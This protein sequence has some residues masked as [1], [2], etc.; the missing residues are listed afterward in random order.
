M[1]S[2]ILFIFLSIHVFSIAQY[3]ISGI[4]DSLLIGANAIKRLHEVQVNIIKPGKA[5]VKEKHVFTILNAEGAKYAKYSTGYSKFVSVD[6]L[7]AVLYDAAGNVVRKAKK[8]D[9]ADFSGTDES[10]LITDY[11]VKSFSFNYQIY[12]YTVEFLEEDTYDGLFSLPGCMPI[13]EPYVSLEKARLLVE[14]PIGYPLLH[15]E[16]EVTGRHEQDAR[17]DRYTWNFASAKAKTPLRFSPPIRSMYPAVFLAPGSFEIEGYPGKLDSWASFGLFMNDLYK[18][19]DI[20]P[21]QERVAINKITAS[22]TNTREKVFATYRYMQQNTRYI[23][24][25]LGLGGWQPLDASFVSTKKYGDCKALS[26]YMVALLK[27]IGI[28]GYNVIIRAGDD[29][30]DIDTDFPSNQFNHVIVCVPNQADT[31]WLECTSQTI[32]PG[33]LGAFTAGRHGILF[34][35]RGGVLVKTPDYYKDVNIQNRF[36]LGSIDASGTLIASVQKRAQGI[37]QDDEHGFVLN[38]TPIDQEQRLKSSI[39]LPHYDIGDLKYVIS[40]DEPLLTEQYTLEANSFA[41]LTDKRIF[42]QPFFYSEFFRKITDTGSR[43]YP[44]YFSNYEFVENDSIVLKLPKGFEPE[45][46]PRPHQFSS[47]FGEYTLNY[48]WKDDQIIVKRKLVCAKGVF[49]P[50]LFGLLARFIEDVTKFD[51]TR[52]VFIRKHE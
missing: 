12:P 33:Y 22:L 41:S 43:K 49:K 37:K 4:P 20:L 46:I 29:E 7:S 19:K 8:K 17:A 36:V 26:N 3:A 40:K 50:E 48:M 21:E 44:I 10:S 38:S 39:Q 23:S 31:I 47:V 51:K 18:S 9:F 42:F 34:D 16:H 24:I 32:A 45:S 5:V 11:R 2:F 6:E 13:G 27:E 28:K 30:Q 15:K 14:A 1:K 52:L 35:E 25:Q